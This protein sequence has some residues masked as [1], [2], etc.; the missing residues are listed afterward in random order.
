SW[1]IGALARPPRPISSRRSFTLRVRS[2]SLVPTV[3]AI[4]VILRMMRVSTRTPS[5]NLF[6]HL[7]PER[8]APTAHRLGI[9]CLAAAYM[10]EVPV[11]QISPHLPLQH[12]I[13]PVPD[14][15]EH[16]QS[17]YHVGR[18][19]PAATA[20]ALGMPFRQ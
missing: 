20:T 11:H 19:T 8:Q 9:R 15:F 10:G 12:L 18:C 2:R 1:L 17:Q 6:E 16:Q 13:A 3:P 7:R 5:P 14:V 4:V